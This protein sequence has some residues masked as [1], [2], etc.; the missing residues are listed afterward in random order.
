MKIGFYGATGS[1]DFGDYAMMVHNIQEIW[2]LVEDSEFYIFSPD[3]YI[4]LQALT[5]NLLDITK[6]R[7]IHVVEEPK[8]AL[9]RA[10]KL[11]DKAEYKFLK[12]HYLYAGKY[13]AFCGGD[14]S[15]LPQEFVEAVGQ[16]DI[17]LFN[18][19]G[20]LQHSWHVSNYIFA[21][22][23]RYAHSKGKP[24]YFLGNSVGPM[25]QYDQVIRDS[26]QYVDRMMVRDGHHYTNKLLRVYGYDRFINGPDDL[27]FVNDVYDCVS[28]YSDYIVIEVM[29]WIDKAGKGAAHILKELGSLI[30]HVT[31]SD[32]NV[33]LVS[34]D[35]S[36]E[37]AMECIDYLYGHAKEKERVYR[38]KKV[39]SMYKMFGLYRNCD[40]S[41]SL[42]Y[43][44]VILSIGSNK[45]FV[46]I[47]CDSD[48][49]Y[50]GKLKGA[51]ENAGIE[52]EKH[53][54]HIDDI[55]E[56]ILTDMYR[57]LI[58]KSVVRKQELDRL[59]TIRYNY[60]REILSQG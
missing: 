57:N 23:I 43:H 15:L 10:E 34:F 36:D 58:G 22:A 19:G 53:I 20:Y 28:P 59:K 51:C 6:I 37:R 2:N 33:V 24:V 13:R 54:L 55:T 29:T 12:N 52:P 21:T 5:D 9:G 40:F 47:I 56:G 11:I 25:K 26:I 60:M 46:G 50:E 18:G 4:T 48:G 17:L 32:K 31:E 45:P 30:D 39:V 8:F 3:K 49:Y 1:W 42:K 41:L 7:K 27:T 16:I 44:P 14:M 38:E 35:R